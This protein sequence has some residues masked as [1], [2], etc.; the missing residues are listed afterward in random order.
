MLKKKKAAPKLTPGIL[1]QARH[2]WQEDVKNRDKLD[3]KVRELTHENNRLK[4]ENDRL[5]DQYKYVQE[6]ME[7]AVTSFFNKKD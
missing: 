7:A 3:D 2:D 5:A 4:A 1:E 6:S